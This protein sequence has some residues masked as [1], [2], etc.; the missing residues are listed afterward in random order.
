MKPAPQNILQVNWLNDLPFALR[1]RC[2]KPASRCSA[3]ER[4]SGRTEL[5]A[6][7]KFPRGFTL[8]ELLVVIAI[9]AILAG[10]LLPAL[11]RSK[12]QSRRASCLNT[13]RQFMLAAHLYATD[14]DDYLPK[15]GTD[16]SNKLD[17]HTPIFSSL[18]ATNL[19]AYLPDRTIDCPNLHESFSRG[20][21]W[22][23]QQEY[24]IAIGYHY[25]GGQSNTPW[26]APAGTTN[27]WIS[28]Q[29]ASDD[30]SLVL[31]ADLN[32]YAYSFL[33]ILAPHT[34]RGAVVRDEPY[35]DAHPEAYQQ[36]PREIGGAGG[37]VG[38]ADGSITWKPMSQMRL[39]RSSQLWEDQG[40]FGLW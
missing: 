33:R 17:T 9:I 3:L 11:S 28:P 12:E 40:S 21:D 34:A 18:A 25:M 38:K 7:L 14:N 31:L 19:L 6:R 22:R 20:K 10:M 32:I 4:P 27:V 35:F 1:V 26:S 8:I 36:T 39:Y 15:G 16:N 2:R 24:G 29:K 23:F 13:G 30:P 37:N 5:G